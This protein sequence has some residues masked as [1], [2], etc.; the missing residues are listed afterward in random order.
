MKNEIFYDIDMMFEGL[1]RYNRNKARAQK[2]V[3]ILT[4][5]YII[6]KKKLFHKND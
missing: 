4:N 3:C 6:N 5:E 2:Y 1:L